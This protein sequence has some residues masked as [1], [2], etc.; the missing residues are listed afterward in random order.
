MYIALNLVYD[1]ISLHIF[2]FSS[3]SS[4]TEYLEYASVFQ[5]VW[6]VFLCNVLKRT[7]DP[8]IRFI[9]SFVVLCL[10]L[11]LC[12]FF[13]FIF[14]YHVF[15]PFLPF[16]FSLVFLIF[17][18]PFALVAYPSSLFSLLSLVS[19]YFIK[20][21]LLLSS[22][23]SPVFF[24]F[25]SGICL[26]HFLWFRFL[27]FSDLCSFSWSGILIFIDSCFSFFPISLFHFIFLF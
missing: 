12:L 2:F 11:S 24:S 20:I 25:F 1:V 21:Y 19:L 3:L 23:F 16:S 8:G 7:L 14:L 6:L 15:S 4:Y 26:P 10:Y 18:F 5:R 17:S 22:S 13:S 9:F 27:T